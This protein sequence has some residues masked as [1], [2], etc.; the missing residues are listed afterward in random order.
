[1]HLNGTR[2]Q[3]SRQLELPFDS[4][5]E[6]PIVGRS[7]EVPLAVHEP[8]R[9]G[10]DD[11]MERVVERSNL[12]AALKRVRSNKGSP[13]VDGMTVGELSAHL[14]EHWPVIREQLLTGNYQPQQVKR[15]TIPKSGGGMRELGIPTVLDRFIQQAL[16]QVLQ[17][18]LDKSFSKHSYG[19]R[20][21]RNAHQAVRAAKHYIQEG[22]RWVVDVDLERFF[23]RVNHDVLMGR[24]AKR[25]EDRRVLAIIRRYLVSRVGDSFTKSFNF[26]QY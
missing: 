22:R 19:F 12:Q 21:G 20:P 15:Q 1:M 9:S 24:L 17:A 5:G 8:E 11:L 4:R 10:R 16:L 7:E 3:M 14:K 26:R 25:I 23:D 18:D 13:G 6:A 2:P